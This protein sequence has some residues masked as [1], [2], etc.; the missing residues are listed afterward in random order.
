[1]S[2]LRVAL[3]VALAGCGGATAEPQEPPPEPRTEVT[4]E[5]VRDEP[6]TPDAPE[7]EPPPEPSCATAEALG[8]AEF[9]D[10][11]CVDLG[12][13]VFVTA[14]VAGEADEL[15]HHVALVSGLEIAAEDG[16]DLVS[17]SA[18]FLEAARSEF[19]VDFDVAPLPLEGSDRRLVL[20]TH[21]IS[22]AREEE[23]RD[24]VTVGLLYEVRD[25]RL[26]HLWSG[27]T[28]DRSDGIEECG[29]QTLVT[30][31]ARQDHLRVQT[32]RGRCGR[33]GPQRPTRVAWPD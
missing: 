23:P 5:V 22:F 12:G 20:V 10:H 2:A 1:M 32:A 28:D 17:D 4:V 31:E 7:P 26:L 15:R 11:G 19:A 14:K 9:R 8:V 6:P 21:A 13:G 30:F 29:R 3:A 25:G 33:L 24:R 27:V 16:R 18:R